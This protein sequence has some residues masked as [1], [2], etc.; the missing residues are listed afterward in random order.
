MSFGICLTCGGSQGCGSARGNCFTCY[1]K[2]RRAVY[3]RVTTW[4]QLERL[5]K[6]LPA[7]GYGKKKKT[8]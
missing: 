3:F 7:K 8:G 6:A 4:R 2:H 1:D 5:G